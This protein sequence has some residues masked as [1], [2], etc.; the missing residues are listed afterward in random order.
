MTLGKILDDAIWAEDTEKLFAEFERLNITMEQFLSKTFCYILAYSKFN[1]LYALLERFNAF[2]NV[3]NYVVALSLLAKNNPAELANSIE[4]T[5]NDW[6]YYRALF[7]NNLDIEKTADKFDAH[8]PAQLTSIAAA[9]GRTETLKALLKLSTQTRLSNPDLDEVYQVVIGRRIP[10]LYLAAKFNQRDSIKIL[11]EWCSELSHPEGG[12]V[13]ATGSPYQLSIYDSPLH[14][15]AGSGHIELVQWLLENGASAQ[16]IRKNGKTIVETAAFYGHIKLVQW[17]FENHVSE[18]ERPTLFKNAFIAAA[19]GGHLELVQWLVEHGQLNKNNEKYSI[20]ASYA[21]YRAALFEHADLVR[22]LHK[23]GA[24][25]NNRPRDTKLTTLHVAAKHGDAELVEYLHKNYPSNQINSTEISGMTPLHLAAKFGH[26]NVVE[27]LHSKGAVISTRDNTNMTPLHS[28]AESGHA[29][30]VQYLHSNGADISTRNNT[31]MTPLHSA[32][33]SGHANVVQY[34]LENK[35]NPSDKCDHRNYT[36][37]HYAAEGGYVAVARCLPDQDVFTLLYDNASVLFVAAELGKTEFV[38]YVLSIKPTLVDT[39]NFHLG[40]PLHVASEFGHTETVQCLLEHKATIHQLKSELETA[41]ML[42]ATYSRKPELVQLLIDNR[43][44]I[45][46]KNDIGSCA[47]FQASCAENKNGDAFAVTKVLLD[48]GA[49]ITSITTRRGHWYPKC[50]IRGHYDLTQK[51]DTAIKEADFAQSLE[52]LRTKCEGSEKEPYIFIHSTDGGKNTFLHRIAK[53][54]DGSEEARACVNELVSRGVNPEHKNA[55]EKT[56][57]DI[58]QPKHHSTLQNL[59]FPSDRAF[60]HIF[61]MS[62]IEKTLVHGYV[63]ISPCPT[64]T[65]LDTEIFHLSPKDA[66]KVFVDDLNRTYEKP[67]LWVNGSS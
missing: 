17:L 3:P 43:A 31:N 21:L 46:F 37:L 24:D 5:S 19:N 7:N 55:D 57:L 62:L 12:I 47:L 25:L 23:N 66:V 32:A 20:I 13:K 4:N 49:D 26:L 44:D 50:V 52:L 41:L 1:M 58:A 38:K 67:S 54:Y 15:A 11:L 2:N 22:W 34:L 42:A 65:Y 51:L 29:D 9:L 33:K 64:T 36:F 10:S 14:Y 27:Y 28:A 16:A 35:A 56:A 8:H 6:P 45:E 61:D 18:Q 39:M 40:T 60:N 30:V 53:H 63:P 48:N 59:F